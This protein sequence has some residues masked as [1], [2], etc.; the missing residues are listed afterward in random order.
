V[1]AR[2]RYWELVPG[3]VDDQLHR[4]HHE[5][6]H[7]GLCVHSDGVEGHRGGG[8]HREP[9]PL[10]PSPAIIYGIFVCRICM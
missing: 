1:A 7:S 5:R 10:V 6:L 4:G 2:G 3:A 8:E 9:F